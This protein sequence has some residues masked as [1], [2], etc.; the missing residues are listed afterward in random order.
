MSSFHLRVLNSVTYFYLFSI[1]EIILNNY[2]F[3]KK[4]SSACC[5]DTKLF[6]D[7]GH[8]CIFVYFVH[9]CSF[10]GGLSVIM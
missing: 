6:I 10:H 9:L 8:C 2:F 1:G 3:R 7:L 5:L 4:L